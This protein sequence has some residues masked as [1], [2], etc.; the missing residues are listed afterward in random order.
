[1]KYVWIREHR[2]SFPLAM[3]CQVL[4]VSPSG[5]YAWLERA[6][7]GGSGSRPACGK[8][9]P[10]RTGFMA[11]TRS[12]DNWL[13]AMNWSPPVATRSLERCGT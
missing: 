9:M 11:A 13:K 8:S 2:D 10:P 4:E 5:Y 7:S 3:L 12:R 1:M 6:P